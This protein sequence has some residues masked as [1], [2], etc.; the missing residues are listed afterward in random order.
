MH[1]EFYEEEE[2]ERIKEKKKATLLM[3][4]GV[5]LKYSDEKHPIDSQAEIGR[6]VEKEYG[7]KIYDRKTN[8]KVIRNNLRI[9]QRFLEDADFGYTLE[10]EYDKEK[11][12]AH[13]FKDKE[14]NSYKETELL[15]GTS[16]HGWYIERDI[17]DAELI[18][19]IDGILFSKYIPQ[20]KR[21][22][23][24]KKLES[25][26]SIHFKR[27]VK[28]PKKESL[29]NHLFYNLELLSEAISKGKRVCFNFLEY[30]TDMAGKP[31]F[32]L[33]K[34]GKQPHIYEVS[35]YEI[36]ITNGR[37]YLICSNS[38]GNL[39]HYRID[40][41]HN[42]NFIKKDETGDDEDSNYVNNRPIKEMEGHENGLDLAKYMREHVYMYTGDIVSVEMIA[43]KVANPSIVGQIR[44]WFGDGVLFSNEDEQFVTVRLMQN[45]FAMLYWALQFGKSVEIIK[46]QPL[47]DKIAKAVKGMY[48]KYNK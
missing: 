21:D 41:I 38:K 45:E 40:H 6:L 30:G 28:L 3:I 11:M 15:E 8:H 23:L 1:D 13:R 32:S 46:P 16:L 20:S 2:K 14:T 43:D 36:I 48:E 7:V 25:H 22:D 17:S 34:D 44:D 19:L 4:L 35:P 39:F 33:G 12:V 31:S 47:R 10:Y 27:D 5:L 24:V 18:P 26:A 29:N 9:L 42:A 37:Y